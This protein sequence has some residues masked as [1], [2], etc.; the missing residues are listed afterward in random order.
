L[1]SAIFVVCERVAMEALGERL[2]R[3][4]DGRKFGVRHWRAWRYRRSRVVSDASQSLQHVSARIRLLA[5]LR[6]SLD[7]NR[8]HRNVFLLLSVSVIPPCVYL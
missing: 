2:P 6:L 8:R 4:H 5:L 1:V 3:S 7:H